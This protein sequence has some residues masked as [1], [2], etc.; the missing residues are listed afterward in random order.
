MMA[1]GGIA[2]W[3][4][5]TDLFSELLHPRH[6]VIFLLLLRTEGCVTSSRLARELDVSPRTI[7]SD[8]KQ[9]RA[10]VE[11]FGIRIDS[12][13]SEGYWLVLQDQ[14][15]SR[16]IKEY[17]QIYQ[18]N[19]VNSDQ[20]LRVQY[21]IRR[22]LASTEPLKT[23]QLQRE[24]YVNESNSLH[25]ELTEV[26]A[27]FSSYHLETVIKPYRG[28][29]IQGELFYKIS[30]M[31]RMYRYFHKH[32]P[33]DI[34]TSEFN[35]LFSCEESEKGKIRN[36]LHK[37]LAN[38]QVVFSD[39]YSERFLIY[40]IFFRNY[41]NKQKQ[42]VINF[43]DICFDYRQTKEYAM[44]DELIQKLR[45]LYS[46]FEFGEEIVKYLSL[47]AVMSSDLYRFRDC[48]EERYGSLIKLA[49][50]L[51]NYILTELSAYFCINMFDDYTCFKDLL[52]IMI[53]ISLKQA[54]KLSDDVDM[55]F[56][57]LAAMD[58]KPILN[59]AIH[60]LCRA[61]ADKYNY[62]FSGREQY[63]L[64]T[65]ILGLFNRITLSRHKLKL[66]LIAIDGRLS[67]QQLKFNL[68][69]Y[70]SQFIEKI[71]TKML[72]ELDSMEAPDYDYYLCMEYGKY[73]N[74]GYSPIYY[75]SEDLAEKE[76]VDSLNDVFLT[77][78]RYQEIL[79]PIHYHKIDEIFRFEPFQVEVIDNPEYEEIMIGHN[80]DIRLFLNFNS[81]KEEF[82]IYYFAD[83]DAVTLHGERYFIVVDT[84]I[85]DNSQKLKMIMNVFDRMFDMP[86][87]LRIQCEEES[88]VYHTFFNANRC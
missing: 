23:E 25:R 61:F 87:L 60:C 43:P 71:E 80:H 78:Y 39:I 19:T 63:L 20:K 12:K 47:T 53:P 69:H 76:Y 42:I 88:A 40:L 62:T 48:S 16:Q 83:E 22:L 34:R 33:A 67:T 35:R 72:Y 24:L 29:V 41:I 28:I 58:R 74:I 13:R 50:E 36:I 45:N 55:G 31:V 79:P 27:F 59:H 21:I 17:F 6:K 10:E 49:E 38:S 82:R 75:A 37:A 5:I 73:M 46:G 44:V 84:G 1:E 54:L 30:C 8:I 11:P 70:F 52:K 85:A 3:N 9:M 86:S 7:K 18:P 57:D 26:K 81:K 51:R 32:G 4:D 56:H 2:L 77:S 15:Q 66:A 68:Q 14:E 64:F 65:T